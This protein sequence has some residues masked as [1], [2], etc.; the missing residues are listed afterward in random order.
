MEQIGLNEISLKKGHKDFVTVVSSHIDGHVQ[1][2]AVL[3]DRK[4]ETV[5]DFLASIPKKLKKTVKS[6][7]CDM[8]DGFINAA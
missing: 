2:L 8:Y 3:K 7:C 1:L 6:V 5:E 4:K